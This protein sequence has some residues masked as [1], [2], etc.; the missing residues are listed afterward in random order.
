MCNLELGRER[1]SCTVLFTRS[2]PHHPS[3]HNVLKGVAVSLNIASR[4]TLRSFN[5]FS[6]SIFPR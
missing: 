4:L 5:N 2:L 3:Y 6:F 1:V